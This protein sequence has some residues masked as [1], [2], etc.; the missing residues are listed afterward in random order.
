MSQTSAPTSHAVV[1]GA[2][3]GGLAAAAAV[4]RHVDLV[5][6]VE[7]DEL[8]TS[9]AAR[10]GTPQGR[11][12]HVLQPGSSAALERL[13]PGLQDDL[14]AAGAVL[15]RAPRDV[16][17]LSAA[18]WMRPFGTR[19]RTMV[20]ASRDLIEW[21]TRRRVLASGGVEV[22]TGV[23]VTG[24]AVDA[25]RVVGVDLRPRGAAPHEP[26]ERMFADLVVDASGRRSH[27]PAWL[28]AAGYERPPE[29]VI[30]AEL[31]Y[32]TRTYRRTGDEAVRG[33]RSVFLQARPPHTTRMGVLFPLEGDRWILTVA[34][35]NGDLPPTDEGGFA[36]FVRQMRSP[37]LADVIEELEPLTPIVGYRRTA[38]QRRH[39]EKLRRAPEG[40]V[41]VGDSACA[42]NPVYGQG[43]G[44][45]AL[46]A[47]ALGRTLEDH[48]RRAGRDLAAASSRIQ[49]AV[50]RAN[51]GTWMVATGEDLRYPGTTG[52][53][54]SLPDRL[55]R[56]YLDRVVAAAASDEEVNAAFFDVVGLVAEPASLL[57]PAVARRVL[58]RRH[59]RP[60]A[61]IPRPAHPDP[62]PA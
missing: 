54:S 5:T 29:T 49:Q 16:L 1:I 2:G 57:R 24:L 9:P 19:G 56:R 20:A 18:G 48:R 26:A 8:P 22:R 50:A 61:D 35:T 28:E 47:E 15:L 7:R 23:E 34:G 4:S 10:S 37:V 13:V 30:D 62:V 32:A 60:P 3:M 43:M 39:Y 33:Y 55:M 36:A 21:G 58:G 53:K 40:F 45:A 59:A 25:G 42:V 51:A 44:A 52:G 12:L 38:N 46:A 14:L 6:I 17:W 11:H 27:A 41:A 31:G